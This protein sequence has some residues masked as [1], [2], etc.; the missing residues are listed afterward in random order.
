MVAF[1]LLPA[2]FIHNEGE[3]L[4]FSEIQYPVAFS[5]YLATNNV[6]PDNDV[7]SRVGMP[8]ELQ[9]N[10]RSLAVK[11]LGKQGGIGLWGISRAHTIDDSIDFRYTKNLEISA[12]RKTL[13]KSRKV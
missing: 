10:P 1:V 3:F 12:S 13:F 5:T 6:R 8:N 11:G 2:G 7:R 4:S 9:E